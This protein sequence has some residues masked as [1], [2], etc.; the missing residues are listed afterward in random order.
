MSFETAVHRKAI[1]L[2]KLSIEM[3]TAAGSGHPSSAL[4]LAHLVTVL[5]YH[6]MRWDPKN[7][8]HPASDRL[9]LSEG[10]A[11]PVIYAAYAD[12]G[13]MIVPLGKSREQARPMTRQDAMALRAIDSPIDG[14]PNPRLGVPFF[15]AAT[16]SL[17]QGLSVGGGLGSAARMDGLDR[18]IYVL[19]GD[20]EAREGQIW[21][22]CDYLVDQSLTNVVPIFNCNE[23]GQSDWVSAQQAR[24]T[25]AKKLEAYGFVVRV[26][27]GHSP[28]EIKGA[29]D[30]LPVIKNGKKPLAIVAR[31]V[32]GWGADAE[33]GTGKHGTPVKKEKLAE[34][35]C[36]LDK[37]A[38][39]LGVDG[40]PADAELKITPPQKSSAQVQ[41]R[42]IRIPSFAD[43]LAKVGLE[44]DLQ[45]GKPIATRR[46][47]GAALLALAQADKRVVGLDAD[48]KNS[49]FSEWLFE[50]LPAQFIECRIAEQNMISVAAGLAA[51][52]KIPFVSTFAKFV[53]R[54][55][56]QIEMAII[57]GAN[58]KVT[59]SHAG[60]TLA[61]DGPS[62]MSLPDVAFFRSFC[63]TKSYSGQPAVRYFFPSDAVSCYRITELMANVN[64]CCY[65]RT[66]RADTRIL[67]KA[68]EDF[69]VGEFKVLR[70][71]KNA[72]LVASGYMVHECL[73]AADELKKAGKT[74][75]VIDA[76]SLPLNVAGLLEIAGKSGGVVVTVEDNYSGGLDAEVGTAIAQAGAALR[77]K[78][79]FV[80]RIPKS[81]REPSEVLD[82]SNVG[83]RAILTAAGG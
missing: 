49:T 15:D 28:R 36:Q 61:A 52:G 83:Q 77:L 11:V 72:C 73:K 1:E 14:H 45:A 65:Q 27:D 8:W 51:A 12:L 80:S 7:P 66:L 30:E 37:T 32:K 34:V 22:A 75:T 47:Y 10:H 23:L 33:Q 56:D 21:E 48:V 9:V 58:F 54:G 31:T 60:V 53:M 6:Q 74:A 24:E 59:G 41:P 2:G 3:T 19:I 55:Y 78:P 20:G 42:P 71:G 16:G 5:M 35:L 38:K 76:Y 39:D 17:G 79:V 69:E 44:K 4:S 43:A 13:G 70:E 26:I 29:L 64:G 68:E 82:W 57:S 40:K 18:N 25:V 67:Y 50:K 46:A 62:Q 63:H 81:G